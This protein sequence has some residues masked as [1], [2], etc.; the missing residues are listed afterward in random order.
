MLA[1]FKF[2]SLVPN[3]DRKVILAELKFG[4]GP[5]GPFI[6]ER[7]RL[8][9]EILEQSHEFANLQ[10]IKLPAYVC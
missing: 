6:K 2:D 7:C 8:L 5:S 3:R 9:L 1:V 10:E 4:G